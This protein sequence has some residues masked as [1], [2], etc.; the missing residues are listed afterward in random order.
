MLKCT[1]FSKGMAGIERLYMLRD[2]AQEDLK[3]SFPEAW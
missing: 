2:R 3:V 1:S